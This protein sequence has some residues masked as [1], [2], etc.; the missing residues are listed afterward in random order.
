M[1]I[2]FR[3]A[4]FC[5][6]IKGENNWCIYNL[7]NGNMISIDKSKYCIL[8]E[9]ENNKPLAQIE[10]IDKEFLNT[11]HNM[12]IGNFYEKPVY[13]D[14]M[15][16]SRPYP[17]NYDESHSV[18]NSL[19]TIF[20]ELNNK[21]NFDCVFCKKNDST[22]YRRTGCKRWPIADTGL[23][24]NK[25]INIIEQVSKLS[26]KKIVFI[27]GEPLLNFNELKTLIEYSFNLGIK[28]IT[29]FTNGSL[30]TQEISSF[31][32]KYSVKLIIQILSYNN[33]TYKKITDKDNM[34]NI[35]FDN[36]Q[37]LN[38]TNV[39]YK[40]MFL[41]NRLNENELD[42]FYNKYEN[43]VSKDKIFIEYIYPLPKN[44]YFSTKHISNLYIKKRNLFNVN[45]SNFCNAQKYHNCYANMLAISVD[46][47]VYP[48]IMSRTMNIG[49][50]KDESIISILS[51]DKYKTY[52][53]ITKD[54]ISTCKNCSYRYGCMDCRAIEISATNNLYGLEYCDKE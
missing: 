41:L 48:C 49:N 36:I 13:I 42:V 50:V 24:T 35:I 38:S 1:R 25:W 14:K 29:I 40:L 16:T 52:T 18:L 5:H 15:D 11:L 23:S 51:K 45:L 10:N 27:G 28:D 19:K 9:C 46:G 32:N 26:C 30:I 39:N 20:I 2:F 44:E 54:K 8:E 7:L 21:C 33:D 22:L 47:N 53:E 4:S 12:N 37:I 43:I 31:F 3:L 17:L 6:L 34:H